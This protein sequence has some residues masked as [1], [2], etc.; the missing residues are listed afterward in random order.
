MLAS[1]TKVQQRRVDERGVVS[2]EY[3]VLGAALILLIG[4]LGTNAAV[5]TALGNAFSNLFNDAG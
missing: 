3:L 4:V 5:Q 2:I 1:I